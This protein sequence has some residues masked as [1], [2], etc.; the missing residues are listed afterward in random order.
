MSGFRGN[1]SDSSNYLRRGGELLA[2]LP[3][4]NVCLRHWGWASQLEMSL[5][6]DAPARWKKVFFQMLFQMFHSLPP[7]QIYA[8][9]KKTKIKE[10][11]CTCKINENFLP[12]PRYCS[13][14][15]FQ[16]LQCGAGTWL[17]RDFLLLNVE[18]PF[19]PLK[20]LTERQELVPDG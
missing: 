17:W 8:Y 5:C 13:C 11:S 15:E 7:L 12:M 2:V 18:F 3:D 1:N 14:Y 4:C 9:R 10:Y 19:I 6:A 16:V 20:I